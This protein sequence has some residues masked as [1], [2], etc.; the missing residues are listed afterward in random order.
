M[1]NITRKTK[2]IIA[3]RIMI[4]LT[5]NGDIKNNTTNNENDSNIIND[6]G[7]AIKEYKTLILI[8]IFITITIRITIN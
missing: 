3:M 1:F 7:Y 4:I 2:I 5:I 6:D 8:V